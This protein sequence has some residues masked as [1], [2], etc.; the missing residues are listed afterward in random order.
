MASRSDVRFPPPES[1]GHEKEGRNGWGE[2]EEKK[3]RT[4]AGREQQ[5]GVGGEEERDRDTDQSS[6]AKGTNGLMDCL[7]HARV[8]G[9]KAHPGIN[10]YYLNLPYSLALRLGTVAA[11]IRKPQRTITR[12]ALPSTT[13]LFHSYTCTLPCLVTPDQQSRRVSNEGRG[14]IQCTACRRVSACVHAR[15]RRLRIVICLR[16]SVNDV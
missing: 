3:I 16:S 5:L 15:R 14:R 6:T 13:T 4:G 10:S 2:R 12:N 8:A 7:I 11:S 1:P 9:K